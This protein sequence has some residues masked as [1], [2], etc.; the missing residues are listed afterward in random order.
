MFTMPPGDRELLDYVRIPLDT[1]RDPQVLSPDLQRSIWG[2][3]YASL[4]FDGHRHFLQGESEGVTRAGR[5]I[6]VLAL[7]PMLA[8]F[9]GLARGLRRAWREPCGPDTPLLLLAGA[10][11]VGFCFFT[12]NNPWF[13]TVKASYLLG[14]CAPF[15]FYASEVLA[16]W[17]EGNRVR[18]SAV[19]AILAALFLAVVV[20]FTFG[21]V[22]HKTDGLGVAWTPVEDR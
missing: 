1:W 12:W 16:A 15:A 22:F 19:G 14:L 6:L 17:T 18:S 3:T 4:Y 2:S 8:M 7:V 20:T 10:T 21:P 9:A 13:A 11:L 5:L